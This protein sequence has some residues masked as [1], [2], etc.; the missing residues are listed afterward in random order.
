MDEKNLENNNLMKNLKE[1][2]LFPII[3][4]TYLIF[5]ILFSFIIYEYVHDISTD[6]SRFTMMHP[7]SKAIYDGLLLIV[8]IA[9][10]IFV[11]KYD[12]KIIKK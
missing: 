11:F 7:F 4:F 2:I 6:F 10:S 8:W 5:T 1:A 3:N 12:R 9:I